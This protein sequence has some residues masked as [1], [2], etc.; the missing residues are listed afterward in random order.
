M[1]LLR[2]H[3]FP[4]TPS[5]LLQL[6]GVCRPRPCLTS[7]RRRPFCVGRETRHSPWCQAPGLRNEEGKAG[8]WGGPQARVGGL[9]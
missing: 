1:Q 8:G 4:L 2:G 3:S 7:G 9:A 5:L 6:H